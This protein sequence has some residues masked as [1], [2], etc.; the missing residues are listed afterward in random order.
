[1]IMSVQPAFALRSSIAPNA[2][3]IAVAVCAVGCTRVAACAV[4]ATATNT[5]APTNIQRTLCVPHVGCMMC[6]IPFEVHIE[7][8]SLQIRF[9]SSTTNDCIY[10]LMCLIKEQILQAH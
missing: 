3:T 10:K 7:E 9:I 8:Y 4:I 5:S 1:M 6:F 2:N